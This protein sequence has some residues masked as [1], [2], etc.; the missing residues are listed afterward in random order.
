[1]FTWCLPTLLGVAAFLVAFPIDR[2]VPFW[3]HLNIAELFGAWFLFIAPAATTVAL[4]KFIKGTKQGRIT[5]TRK[6][7]SLAVVTVAFL[8]NLLLLVGLYAATS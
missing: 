5:R 4:V 8:L 1:V 7:L 3:P 2:Q 6:W